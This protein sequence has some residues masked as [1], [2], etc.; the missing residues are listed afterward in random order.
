MQLVIKTLPALTAISLT[1]IA[2]LL[3][4][5][6][7]APTWL[8]LGSS[9]IFA[10]AL[11][12]LGLWLIPAIGISAFAYWGNDLFISW[13]CTALVSLFSLPSLFMIGVLIGTEFDSPG[14]G[15]LSLVCAGVLLVA[16][17]AV[18]IRIA[19]LSRRNSGSRTSGPA[20]R[21]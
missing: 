7:F 19:V 21:S 9:S 5:A 10:A 18:C 8:T 11:F 3:D 17:T 12:P 1:V 15:R 4:P 14:S 2:I 16:S 20:S 13:L 6:I